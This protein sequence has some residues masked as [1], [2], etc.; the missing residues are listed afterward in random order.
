G[1]VSTVV[2]KKILPHLSADPQLQTMFM[3]E[4]RVIARLDHPNIVHLMD[5][6]RIDDQ[7]F[8][9]L[10]Y[11][12]GTDLAV[13]S[14]AF[15][16]EGRRIPV[17]TVLHVVCCVLD[18]LEYAH[19][20]TRPDGTPL[21]IVH[22]DVSPGNILLSR[23]G[24]VKLTDFGIAKA[25]MR[26][27]EQTRVGTIKGNVHYMAPEQ[28]TGRD[29]DLRADLYALGMV[30]YT[31]LAGR[32]P[33]EGEDV[34]QTIFRVLGGSL[35]PITEFD[36]E[37]P[38]AL[39]SIVTRATRIIPAL[40]FGSAAEFRTAILEFAA[41]QKLTLG[42]ASLVRDIE[43]AIGAS[44]LP[45]GSVPSIVVRLG[46]MIAEA[47][48]S[49][50][51]SVFRTRGDAPAPKSVLKEPST[52]ATTKPVPVAGNS[53][54]VLGSIPSASPTTPSTRPPPVS[55]TPGAISPDSLL[56][57]LEL[58]DEPTV[59]SKRGGEAASPVA[60]APDSEAARDD[61]GL[62]PTQT[63]KVP[64]PRATPV[65]PPAAPLGAPRTAPRPAARPG[66]AAG[67]PDGGYVPP[68]R[69]HA[70]VLEG[71]RH[72]VT[73][74]AVAAG[75]NVLLSASHD[76]TIRVWNVAEGK[77][78]RVLRGHR[79]K[80]ECLAA[81]SDGSRAVSGARDRTLK[82]WNVETGEVI[83]TFAGHA[84]RIFAIAFSE[85][86]RH[87]LSGGNDR[88]LMLWSIDRDVPLR[89][90]GGHRDAVTSVAFFPDGERAVS[91]SYDCTLRIWDLTSAGQL[92]EIDTFEESVRAVAISPDGRLLLSAGADG[93]I[94][95]WDSEHPTPLHSYAGHAGPVVSIRFSP[96]GK[97]FVS[98]SYDGTLRLWD[99]F[100]GR[101]ICS[102]EG[103][104]NAVFSAVFFPD[105]RRIASAG[106]DNTIR[107]WDV[108]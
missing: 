38:R 51:A 92:L 54:D 40:R 22:R 26:A 2:V 105:G 61:G 60:A 72:P 79:G 88:T 19:A 80:I 108:P 96:D 101:A 43:E 20:K 57:S 39:E 37:I 44:E 12:N 34:P 58:P 73:A 24:M 66:A 11:V 45:D 74:L 50:D 18:A 4:A 62:P 31:M 104:V 99:V 16:G 64:V 10:E 91:G 69:S 55:S 36:R 7:L 94:R 95:L 9:A 8:L 35:P 93:M 63:M 75:G 102:F 90:I 15:R 78:T 76:E 106:S 23:E 65:A 82:L 5:V 59:T 47:V 86:G 48:A 17:E 107:L 41:A 98:A 21:N 52:S 53:V 32:N 83:R 70:S 33:F 97:T 56:R 27:A 42:R 89:T 68:V 29:L 14:R 103:H 13:L 28:I 25:A 1:I 3:D 46:P 71:H 30:L 100:A 49:G 87:I 84:D 77:T 81:T 67:A 85:D 6:G